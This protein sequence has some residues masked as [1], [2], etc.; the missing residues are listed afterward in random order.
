MRLSGRWTASVI[1]STLLAAATGCSLNAGAAKQTDIVIGADL[2]STSPTDTAY[3]SALQLMVQQV[4]ASGQLG[5]RQLVLRIE[6]NHLDPTASLSN[7]SGLAADPAVA[8][9]VLGSCGECLALSAKTIDEQKV[10]TIA[11]AAADLRRIPAAGQHWIFKLGPNATDDAAAMRAE[12]R[13]S[14]LRRIAVLYADDAAGTDAFAAL[15]SN[16]G[17]RAAHLGL[18]ATRKIKAATGD[19]L[20]NKSV[21]DLKRA[22]RTLAATRPD[23][24]VLLTGPDQANR[25]AIAARAAGFHGRLLLDAPAAGDLFLSTEAAGALDGARLV[26]AKALGIDDAIATAP[27]A[28]A[29]R[30]WLSDVTAANGDFNGSTLF[31]ADAAS[32]LARAVASAGGD[33]GGIREALETSVIDG[34]SGPIRLTATNHSGLQAPALTVLVARG[35]RW[36]LPVATER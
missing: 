7:V 15:T 9:I 3:T 16:A 34:L 6:D 24:M 30:E 17:L 2:A 25:A 29:Q 14:G 20:T 23:A 18:S 19:Q 27:A 32:L 13:R 36:R 31:A 26:F 5:N 33:R 21:A 28:T 22:V 11:L 4:N 12:L 10:P 1:A 8:A 35:G